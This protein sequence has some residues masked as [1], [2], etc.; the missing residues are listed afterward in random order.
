M[1][2]DALRVRVDALEMR[3]GET[4]TVLHTLTEEVNDVRLGNAKI[5]K[6]LGVLMDAQG[7]PMVELTEDEADE[8]FE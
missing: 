6:N 1:S 5:L 8:L 2:D 3:A 7:V 4:D